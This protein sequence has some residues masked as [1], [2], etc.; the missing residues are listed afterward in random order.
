MCKGGHAV[1]TDEP[2]HAAT[3]PRGYE[4]VPPEARAKM[5]R[6]VAIGNLEFVGAPPKAE[7][8]P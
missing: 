6:H 4:D 7:D 3:D 2:H 8:Y 1:A 5:E